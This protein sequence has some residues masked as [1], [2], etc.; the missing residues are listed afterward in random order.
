MHM[1]RPQIDRPLSRERQN[2]LSGNPIKV[3]HRISVFGKCCGKMCVFMPQWNN[4]LRNTTKCRIVDGL[5]QQ[6]TNL[7]SFIKFQIGCKNVHHDIKCFPISFSWHPVDCGLSQRG[8]CSN[9]HSLE[10]HRKWECQ[11]PDEQGASAIKPGLSIDKVGFYLS[12]LQFL[13][14]RLGLSFFSGD[15]NS[16]RLQ[17]IWWSTV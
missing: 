11:F 16:L 5:F 12:E 10:T 13:A 6:G 15:E 9:P 2:A 3:D 1:P 7:T 17:R 4:I 14:D 8:C